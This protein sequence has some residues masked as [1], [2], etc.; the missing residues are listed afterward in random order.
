G[1][2]F[3]LVPERLLDLALSPGVLWRALEGR[4]APLPTSVDYLH[5]RS[6]GEVMLEALRKTVET[7]TAERGPEVSGWGWRLGRIHFDPLPP[8]PAQNR[9]TF[10][11]VVDLDRPRVHGVSILPPGQSEDPA[12][13]HFGDQRELAGYWLFKPM[14]D[15]RQDL[16]P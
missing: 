6:A 3:A 9:G 10:I 12:S 5:G 13:P 16:E 1:N 7:L 2:R 4:R 14:I 15:R 11:Q 8:I